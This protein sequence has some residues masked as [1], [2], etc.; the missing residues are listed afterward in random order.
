MTDANK[1]A[2]IRPA[3]SERG[4]H[5]SWILTAAM[6]VALA[7]FLIYGIRWQTK[8]PEPVEVELIRSLPAIAVPPAP[9]FEPPADK[10]EPPVV[11][12]E[13][14]I[15][16]PAKPHVKVEPRPVPPP[17]K[18]QIALKEKEKPKPR[19][20]EPAPAPRP[21]P[22][23]EQLKREEAERGRRL[24]QTKAAESAAKELAQVKH[25]QAGV[26]RSKIV[27]A[28]INQI[29]GKV[30]GNIVLPPDVRGNP[31]AIF[32]VTQLPSGEV[33]AVRLKQTSGQPALDA[34]IERA[35][36]KSSPLPK[37]EQPSAFV[38]D[39]EIRFRPLES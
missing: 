30:R 1:L 36:L 21:D 38:R 19:P 37:P 10:L 3:T 34:A 29:R 26:E 25:A 32:D 28:W 7:V 4:K 22:F 6:H 33:I 12:P 13:P 14:K 31:E 17:A 16:P 9:T 35:I 2:L 20:V 23:Q 8:A 27:S 24:D 11:K 5:W 18:P 15:E 39:L